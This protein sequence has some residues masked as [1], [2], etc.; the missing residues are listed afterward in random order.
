[1][2]SKR[3]TQATSSSDTFTAPPSKRQKRQHDSEL[4][5][6]FISL[7]PQDDVEQPLASDVSNEDSSSCSASH[8]DSPSDAQEK[9]QRK[10]NKKASQDDATAEPDEKETG[11]RT[12][13]LLKPQ[14]KRELFH[15]VDS[16]IMTIKEA[17]RRFK[18]SYSCAKAICK[19]ER[20]R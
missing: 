20:R 12:Y 15:L 10:M 16:H 18:I 13:V 1:M 4:N 5:R 3:D 8:L 6:I 14:K 11:L 17:S 19:R 2:T 9:D 7:N